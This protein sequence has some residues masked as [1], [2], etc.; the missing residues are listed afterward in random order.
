M[1]CTKFVTTVDKLKFPFLIEDVEF[2]FSYNAY[3]TEILVALLKKH[4]RI[5]KS[6]P[7]HN[8]T[9][10]N[11]AVRDLVQLPS[12]Y[13]SFLRSFGISVLLQVLTRFNSL[14]K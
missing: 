6:G 2:F 12:S 11:S 14:T 13:L 8:I 4:K 9:K 1:D 5:Q 7:R 10:Y 3:V